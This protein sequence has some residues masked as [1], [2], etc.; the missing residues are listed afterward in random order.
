[1]LLQR[2][3]IFGRQTPSQ[4]RFKQIDRTSFVHVAFPNNEQRTT[5]NEP[6]TTN[7]P[8]PSPAPPRA[9]EQALCTSPRAPRQ[10]SFPI[11][12][13]PPSFPFPQRSFPKTPAT[14]PAALRRAPS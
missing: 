3:F 11:F 10:P 7:P 14:S 5:D 13:Q 1:M 2:E 6:R 8:S 9:T 4:R 12:S